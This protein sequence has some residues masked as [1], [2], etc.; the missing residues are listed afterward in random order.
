S[1][2]LGIEIS[3][4]LSIRE[5]FYLDNSA[6]KTSLSFSLVPSQ[7]IDYG[8][9]RVDVVGVDKAGNRSGETSLDLWILSSEKAEILLMQTKADKEQ[10]NIVE[11][12]KE[13]SQLSL[14]ELEKKAVL[15]REKEISEFKKT[16]QSL[17]DSTA[18]LARNFQNL[19][20]IVISSFAG[21]TKDITERSTILP[22]Q[23]SNATTAVAKQVNS[24]VSSIG[25]AYQYTAKTTPKVIGNTML[26]VASFN[27]STAN[28]INNSQENAKNKIIKTQ[29]GMTQIFTL[30]FS[31]AQNFV[32][33]TAPVIANSSEAVF[34][35]FNA[36]QDSAKKQIVE[37]HQ[38]TSNTISQIGIKTRDGVSVTLRSVT[39]P[40]VNS[41]N[42]AERFIKSTTIAL[43]TFESYMFDDTPTKIDNVALEEVGRDYAVV[44]WKTNHYT[45]SNKVNYGQSLTYGQSAWGA[46]GEKNH[47][48]SLTGLK[49]G[50]KYYFEVMSQNKNYA[51]DAYYSFETEK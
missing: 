44:T 30:Q 29:Q 4:T 12:I 37:T 5:T 11:K 19:A 10:K 6:N 3:R 43:V 49:P 42:F 45:N 50:E 26:A 34:K 2:L 7:N 17:Q 25:N 35:R 36:S 21:M 33:N 23:L 20:S 38:N 24:T 48:V 51:Y 18:Y 8:Q 40:A 41:K 28:I 22:R 27:V 32:G 1:F 39:K 31:N 46:D 15:R 14:P 16:I 47:K 9:Y 13:S